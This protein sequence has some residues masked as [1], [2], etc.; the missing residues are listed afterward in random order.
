MFIVESVRKVELS[1]AVK[2]MILP[3]SKTLKSIRR[4]NFMELQQ[5]QTAIAEGETVVFLCVAIKYLFMK[6]FMWTIQ[7][8]K[9]FDS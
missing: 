4:F 9:L 7:K 6:G 3:Y 5:N 2:V 1:N 8:S